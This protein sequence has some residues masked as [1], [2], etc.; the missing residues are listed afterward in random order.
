MKE[1]AKTFL[2]WI[3]TF[4][5]LLVLYCVC[6]SFSYKTNA[7]FKWQITKTSSDLKK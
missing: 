3:S 5:F 4:V 1:L 6:S 7:E 2:F